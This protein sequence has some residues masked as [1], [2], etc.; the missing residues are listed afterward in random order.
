MPSGSI[1]LA[2]VAAHTAGPERWTA[3]RVQHRAGPE[4]G[5]P[6]LVRRE[7]RAVN[8]VTVPIGGRDSTVP[9][10]PN[11]G[12]AD[13]KI[14]FDNA[15]WTKPRALVERRLRLEVAQKMR[16]DGSLNAAATRADFKRAGE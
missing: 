1:S 7:M 6:R 15:S 3:A 8:R 9:L 14:A 2:Q 5:A 13:A 16:P 12:V 10:D 11:A 4:S